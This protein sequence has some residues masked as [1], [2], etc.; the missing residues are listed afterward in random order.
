M[1]IVVIGAGVSGLTFA[2]AMQHFSPQTQV[3]V[4]ERDQSLASRPRGYSLGLKGDAGLAV[5]KTLGLYE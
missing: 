3:E 4:Y 2:A 5:L 1:K